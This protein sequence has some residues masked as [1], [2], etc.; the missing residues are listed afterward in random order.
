[1]ST[2]NPFTLTEAESDKEIINTVDL[3]WILSKTIDNNNVNSEV[4]T[5]WDAY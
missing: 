3:V 1:M 2:L 5:C 4:T